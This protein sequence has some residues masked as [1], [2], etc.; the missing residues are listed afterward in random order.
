MSDDRF[1]GVLPIGTVVRVSEVGLERRRRP[2][3]AKIA[4]YDLGRTKYHLCPEY[5]PGKY[6]DEPYAWAFLSEAVPLYPSPVDEF[7]MRGWGYTEQSFEVI[8]PD[9][10]SFVVTLDKEATQA[11]GTAL[12]D[13]ASRMESRR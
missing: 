4:G 12:V 8:K 7:R 13:R 11:L 6:A 10:L 1:D 9:G 3:N 2:Y 5:M